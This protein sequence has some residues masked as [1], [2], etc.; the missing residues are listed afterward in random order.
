MSAGRHRMRSKLHLAAAA[1]TATVL[2]VTT[3]VWFGYRELIQPSCSGEIRLAVAVAPEL[4]PAVDAA[5]S[6]WVKDGAAV[7]PTCIRVDVSA[8]DPVDVAAV[9]AAKH[10]AVL[11]GVGQA[12]GTA[13]SPDV[14]VP[15]SSTWLLR[16]K[17][18]ASAFAPTNGA[19]IARSP[20]VVAMPE[21][22]AARLGWPNRK[23]NWTDLLKQVSN[24]S[25]PLRTGIVEPTRDAA[26]LS[27][28]LSLT[29][30]ASASGGDTQGKTVG[31]LRALATGRSSLRNDLLARFPTA[32]DA[33]SI[34]SGLGAAALSE[35]DVIAYNSKKPPVPL[36]AL[37]MEPAPMP[38]DYPYAVLP[39]IEPTKASAARVLFELLTSPSFR[40]RLAAQSLRA[41][42]G[43]WGD[44]FKAPQGAPSPSGGAPTAPANGG[45]AAGGLDPAAIQRVVSSWSIATQ[46][47]RML[48][49]IDVSGSMKD[50]VP[51]ANN[52]SREE[53]TVDAARRGLGLFDDSW[54]IGLWTFSTKL[55]GSR[56]YKE[57]VGIGPLSGQRAQLEAALAT[58][59]PSDGGTGLYDTTLAAYKAVQ[60]DWQPGRVNSIVLFTDGENE[61]S[62]GISQGQLLAELK[63]VADPERPVQVIMIGIGEGVSKAELESITKVTGGDVFVTKDPN[64]IGSIFL[65]AIARRP[66]APR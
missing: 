12:S 63:R 9:V 33:T 56:D 51:S 21:P 28:L 53:V 58:V 49:V 4:A 54:S 60:E 40:D 43:N 34:A 25:A 26:G 38:L 50:P 22:I 52:R 45:T 11:A 41:P 23:F 42:D 61:D 14:W 35:E 8:S 17:K 16:L 37:Y 6:Q 64:E 18:E 46:S 15:D 36:A 19:P 10:G 29:A 47:G 24:T 62:N 30:A 5:A 59:K 2:V 7:G 66:P 48:A 32:N 3:G 44:G 27:G 31:A 65:S 13:V 20:I 55:V 57:L 1:A 39:G